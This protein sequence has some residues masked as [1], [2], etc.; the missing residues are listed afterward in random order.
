MNL[1]EIKSGDE[2][3]AVALQ[4]NY[5]ELAKEIEHNATTIGNLQKT[6][7]NGSTQLNDSI[8][9]SKSYLRKGILYN[10]EVARKYN[11]M[12]AENSTKI[13]G[14]PFVV[15]VSSPSLLPSW[16][17]IWSDGWCEQGGIGGKSKVTIELLHKYVDTNYSI[18]A[19]HRGGTLQNGS[20]GYNVIMT[21]NEITTDSFYY[22]YSGGNFTNIAWVTR[23]Y[24]AT[25]P[26]LT[27]KKLK[28]QPDKLPTKPPVITDEVEQ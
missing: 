22:N 16:Y 19:T 25:S 12:Y 9:V 20:G 23:G 3:D 18:L 10:E 2:V 26:S 6:Q 13:D 7:T 15:E 28:T 21:I 24:L 8:K 17:R 27:N 5:Q 14:R 1:I 4:H 11:E